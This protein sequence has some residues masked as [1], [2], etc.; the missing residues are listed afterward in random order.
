MIKGVRYSC[1][2]LIR[3]VNIENNLKLYESE[4]SVGTMTI[5]LS[6]C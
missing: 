2:R 4:E 5:P 1:S 3:Y 6:I